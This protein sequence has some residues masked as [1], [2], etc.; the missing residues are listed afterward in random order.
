[1]R[2]N[3]I[4]SLEAHYFFRRTSCTRAKGKFRMHKAFTSQHEARVCAYIIYG[5]ERPQK[6]CV[7]T[8]DIYN[9]RE[10]ASGRHSQYYHSSLS[11]WCATSERERERTQ[12]LSVI[13]CS[14]GRRCSSQQQQQQRRTRE[15]DR[16][17]SS[18]SSSNRAPVCIYTY[19]YTYIYRLW[20]AQV[21]LMYSARRFEAHVD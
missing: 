1:M 12:A 3:Y 13:D 18:S 16:S 9:S 20:C 5:R 14:A 8:K 17:R 15:I 21:E 10:A 11:I 7:Y 19:T 2:E 4:F 6:R